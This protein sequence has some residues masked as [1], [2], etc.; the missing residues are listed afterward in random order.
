VELVWI[1]SMECFVRFSFDHCSISVNSPLWSSDLWA[2][3]NFQCINQ[4][5][6]AVEKSRSIVR[7]DY[8]SYYHCMFHNINRRFGMNKTT[9]SLR[10]TPHTY[11]YGYY[12]IYNDVI[13]G[14]YSNQL[15]QLD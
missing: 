6:R 11:R 7:L 14:F 15:E 5:M 12:H 1:L 8:Q 4:V 2:H 3:V 10:L 13:S 9:K